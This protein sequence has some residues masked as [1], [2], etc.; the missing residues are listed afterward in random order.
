VQLRYIF[1]CQHAIATLIIFAHIFSILGSFCPLIFGGVTCPIIHIKTHR[2]EPTSAVY[3]KHHPSD[4]LSL[5]NKS[6]SPDREHW[7]LCKELH[8]YRQHFPRQVDTITYKYLQTN[9]YTWE[10]FI[11]T[12]GLSLSYKMQV[13]QIFCLGWPVAYNRLGAKTIAIFFGQKNC[14]LAFR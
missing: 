11:F 6:D 12:V 9:S 1:T 14:F 3:I 4:P 2:H 7:Q 10:F 13:L 5:L 8:N